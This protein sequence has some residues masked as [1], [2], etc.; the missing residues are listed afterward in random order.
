MGTNRCNNCVKDVVKS[1]H[2][3]CNHNRPVVEV[4]GQD[5]N[6]GLGTINF[7]RKKK[8][9]KCRSLQ[10]NKIQLTMKKLQEEIP[11]NEDKNPNVDEC[12]NDNGI[13]TSHQQPTTTTNNNKNP[14]GFL[15][16]FPIEV[17]ETFD[18]SYRRPYMSVSN[19][20]RRNRVNEM[21]QKIIATNV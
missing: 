21:A 17:L 15:T 4:F 2:T 16:K 18:L 11:D 19:I 13:T 9:W 14:V 7:E 10:Q 8:Y 12:T 5:L 1:F 20:I 3:E 6:A